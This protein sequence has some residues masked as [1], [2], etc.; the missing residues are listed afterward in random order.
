MASVITEL[1]D[2]LGEC[3]PMNRFEVQRGDVRRTSA[4]TC[5]ARTSLGCAAP[6]RT[7]SGLAT[8]LAWVAE[9]A[10]AR[11]RWSR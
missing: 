6:R 2:L 9:R 7:A 11:R 10:A 1:E 5:V 4:D 3:I 8:E